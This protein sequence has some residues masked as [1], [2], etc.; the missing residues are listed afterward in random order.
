MG[1][2]MGDKLERPIGQKKAKAILA[3]AK[4]KKG[5]S[6]A[7]VSLSTKQSAM[8]I[9]AASSANLAAAIVEKNARAKVQS[10]KDEVKEIRFLADAGVTHC[11]ENAAHYMGLLHNHQKKAAKEAAE[12]ASALLEAVN[13]GTPPPASRPVSTVMVNALAPDT[14]DL[15]NDNEESTRDGADGAAAAQDGAADGGNDGL[16][17]GDA[18]FVGLAVLGRK[19]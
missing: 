5:S 9:M 12:A 13:L 18:A 4:K 8:D 6:V 2:A 1:R 11:E 16:D 7:S 19:A 17:E 10:K 15:T 3:S 14:E